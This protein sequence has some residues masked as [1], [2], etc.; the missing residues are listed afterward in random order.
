MSGSRKVVELFYDVVSPYSWLAFEVLC[1]YRN[2]WNIDLKLKP[3][4]LG[5]VM[6]DSGNRPPGMIP[7]KFL[8]M[9]SDLKHVSEYFGVPVR[10]PSNVF[11]TMFEKGSLKAMRFVTAV[12]EKEKEGDVKLERVSRELW[13]RIWSN[14]QDITLPASFAEA[15]LKAGLTASEVDELLTLAT[16]QP[17][18]DKLKSVTSEAIKYKCFGFPTIVCHVDGKPEIFFGS[19]RFEVMAHI[20]GEKWMGPNPVKP[21]A[22]M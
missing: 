11:E 22:K 5:A 4:F 20:I 14:D 1:R 7:N 16:S 15:G 8:Y 9:T 13:N 12:A 18:K 17:I 2:V 3:A 19:D 6:H 21:M 10:Q